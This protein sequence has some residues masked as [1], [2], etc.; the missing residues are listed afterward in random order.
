MRII[1][2]TLSLVTLLTGCV[3]QFASMPDKSINNEPITYSEQF[4]SASEKGLINPLAFVGGRADGDIYNKYAKSWCATREHNFRELKESLSSIC[5]E[6]GGTVRGKWCSSTETEA[7]LFKMIAKHSVSKCSTGV[8]SYVEVITPN[9]KTDAN[10]FDWLSFAMQNDFKDSLQIEQEN[11]SLI[12]EE[13][14]KEQKMKAKML[15]MDIMHK[16][17]SAIMLSEIG[18]QVCRKGISGTYTGYVENFTDKKMKV[19]V[20]FYGGK[21]WS[22]PGFKENTIWDSTDHW[23]ICE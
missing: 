3:N 11:E 17:E 13:R 14:I 9:G 18:T 7:P 5:S 15:K 10:G 4:V 12:Q 22:V 20:V 1:L 16:K 19:R 8:S 6:K 21:G 23:Y 2:L